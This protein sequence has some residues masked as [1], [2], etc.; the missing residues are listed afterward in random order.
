MILQKIIYTFIA[1]CYAAKIGSSTDSTDGNKTHTLPKGKSEISVTI[2]Q[3]VAQPSH[4]APK[5]PKIQIQNV[6]VENKNNLTTTRRPLMRTRKYTSKPHEIHYIHFR[7]EGEHSN[8]SKR[9][10]SNE[11]KRFKPQNKNKNTPNTSEELSSVE[12]RFINFTDLDDNGESGEQKRKVS[13]NRPLKRRRGYLLATAASEQFENVAPYTLL[14]ADK[15]RSKSKSAIQESLQKIKTIR[16]EMKRKVITTTKTPS[17]VNDTIKNSVIKNTE[18]NAVT[19]SENLVHGVN[20]TEKSVPSTTIAD[21]VMYLPLTTQKSLKKTENSVNSATIAD[22]VIYLPKTTTE[23]LIF[24]T[25]SKNIHG[26][27]IKIENLT[28]ANKPGKLYD[29]LTS[30]E[31]SGNTATTWENVESPVTKTENSKTLPVTT[32]KTVDSVISIDNLN[33]LATKTEITDH[34]TST[35]LEKPGDSAMT[36]KTFNESATET[37]KSVDSAITTEKSE[38]NFMIITEKPILPAIKIEISD[39]PESETMKSMPLI[40]VTGKSIPLSTL[41]NTVEAITDSEIVTLEEKPNP[42]FT[43][44]P[45]ENVITVTPIP[46]GQELFTTEDVRNQL[47]L[48]RKRRINII[49]EESAATTSTGSRFSERETH[50]DADLTYRNI[51]T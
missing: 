37:Q 38:N 48:R 43:N 39:K 29:A 27:Q 31:K 11:K 42:K 16:P 18:E 45:E 46:N 51:H 1:I 8:Y 33:D 7:A 21:K 5:D 9:R 23:K 4:S 30:T 40:I 28:S 49:E 14:N 47:A 22:K 41:D 44:E 34:S 19:T 35:A 13:T 15:Y 6:P 50:L 25:T 17:K 12:D 10:N 36:I 26:S 32:E 24:S 2:K 3:H 20:T